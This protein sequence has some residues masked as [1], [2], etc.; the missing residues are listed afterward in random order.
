MPKGICVISTCPTII[1]QRTARLKP[2][3]EYQGQ[4]DVVDITMTMMTAV[5]VLAD[6][7]VPVAELVAILILLVVTTTAVTTVLVTTVLVTIVL[8]TI[9]GIKMCF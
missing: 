5:I 2:S 4:Q 7:T 8:V 3:K 9:C 1:F 6:L